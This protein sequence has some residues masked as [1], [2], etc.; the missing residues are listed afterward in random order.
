MFSGANGDDRK[1]FI[2][3]VQLT[4]SRIGNLSWL[5]LTFATSNNAMRPS[6]FRH[7]IYLA[8]GNLKLYLLVFKLHRVQLD[9]S[10]TT[11]NQIKR[12]LLNK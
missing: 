6:C 8:C 3:S 10:P 2:I 9:L 4:T 5:I 12:I 7:I 1:M 11:T